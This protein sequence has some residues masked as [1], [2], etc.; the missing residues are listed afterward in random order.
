[1]AV[2]GKGEDL[3]FDENE[4]S[5]DSYLERLEQFFL[6]NALFANANNY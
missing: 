6:A 2:F 1:M 4:E 5:F 3:N